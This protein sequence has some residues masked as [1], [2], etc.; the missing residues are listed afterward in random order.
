MKVFV[1]YGADGEI[2]GA[3]I[4]SQEGVGVRSP[5]S[6]Q[7]YVFE[8]Q[9][10]VDEREQTKFLHDLVRSHRIVGSPPALSKIEAR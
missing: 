6:H 2:R 9:D 4:S 10:I 1:M 8:R 3:A 7:L 5:G